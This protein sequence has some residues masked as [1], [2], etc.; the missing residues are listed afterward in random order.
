MN[1]SHKERMSFTTEIE[2]EF[3]EQVIDSASCNVG[4]HRGS[5]KLIDYD[6]I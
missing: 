5:I 4:R 2:A 6:W 1:V 3:P